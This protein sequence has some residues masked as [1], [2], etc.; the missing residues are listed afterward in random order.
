MKLLELSNLKY[1]FGRN[2]SGL[3]SL[4]LEAAERVSV[5]GPSGVGKTLLLRSICMLEANATSELR[6]KGKV[7]SESEIPLYRS[8]VIYVGQ[9]IVLLPGTVRSVFKE[10]FRLKNHKNKLWNI[11]STQDALR[12]LGKGD[13][14]LDKTT[15]Y[16]SGGE[17]Q[18]VHLLLA[19]ALGPEL[20]CLDEPTS[21]LDYES[22]NKMESWLKINYSGAWVW[23]THHEDQA[24]RVGSRQILLQK[25]GLGS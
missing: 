10:I 21:A 16:L 14:F 8:Q 24:K 23:V 15:E 22:T 9:K 18:I 20:L 13:D 2:A 4:S 17:K 12:I 11:Q 3:Q 6:W 5:M 19:V 7:L 1:N 25:E